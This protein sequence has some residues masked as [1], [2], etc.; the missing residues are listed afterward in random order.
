MMAGERPGELVCGDR[1]DIALEDAALVQRT[2]KGDMRAFG[3]LVA[4]YQ[5]RIFN[6]ILRMCPRHAEAEELTQE[7]FLRALERIGQFRGNSKFYTWLFRIGANLTLSHRRRV[8][9]VRFQSLSG[10]DEFDGTQADHLTAAVAA[11]RQVN[12][13]A[14]AMTAET[15]T[16][17][18]EAL[19]ELDDEFRLVVLLRDV[20]EMDYDQ[21][22]QVTGL[23]L[24]TV[25]SRL[26]RARCLLRQSLASL[27]EPR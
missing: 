2:R 6:L 4:K 17:V 10:T 5:D 14:A 7:T 1:S 27:M 13:A 18:L 16:R 15:R 20:E 3:M 23:P 26:H 11:K 25:K 21:I 22:S 9:R 8:G 24:G 19:E 12:P